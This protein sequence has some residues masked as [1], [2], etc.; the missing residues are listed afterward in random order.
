MSNRKIP[1]NNIKVF[2]VYYCDN[3]QQG[4]IVPEM[5][6]VSKWEEYKCCIKMNYHCITTNPN[7]HIHTNDYGLCQVAKMVCDQ[8]YILDVAADSSP[9]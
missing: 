8:V 3:H 1:H 7:Y 4:V 2:F 5:T 9:P 6:E